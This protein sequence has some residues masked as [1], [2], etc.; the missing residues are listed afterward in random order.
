M[1]AY[2]L[3]NVRVGLASGE[4][5]GIGEVSGDGEDIRAVGEGSGVVAELAHGLEDELEAVLELG[6]V[7]CRFCQH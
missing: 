2:G 7:S 5:R 4:V 1:S 6:L 3:L